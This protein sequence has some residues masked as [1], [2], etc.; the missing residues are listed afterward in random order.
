VFLLFASYGIWRVVLHEMQV[1]KS[2][3]GGGVLL[4]GFSLVV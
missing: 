1:P 2:K 4:P 3:V